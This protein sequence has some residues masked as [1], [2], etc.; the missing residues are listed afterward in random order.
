MSESAMTGTPDAPNNLLSGATM[1][2]EH[3]A[4]KRMREQFE[5]KYGDMA[6][7]MRAINGYRHVYD[8][9]NRPYNSEMSDRVTFAD[10]ESAETA[11]LDSIRSESIALLSASKP[12]APDKPE[13]LSLMRAA[14]RVTEAEGNPDPAKQRFH[15]RFTFRSMDEMHAADDQW[16]AFA[17]APAAP[18]ADTQDERGATEIANGGA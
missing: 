9:W 6:N 7:V 12:A 13:S 4:A 3:P 16:H 11:M 14:F 1:T 2:D 18:S 10:L 17:A 15:M 5:A 8:Q